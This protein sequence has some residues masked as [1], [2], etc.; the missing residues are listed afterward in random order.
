M[1][2]AQGFHT[3]FNSEAQTLQQA[4]LRHVAERDIAELHTASEEDEVDGVLC[5][6]KSTSE[7][8]VQALEMGMNQTTTQNPVPW[9]PHWPLA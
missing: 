7:K 1:R 8:T 4:F 3:R 2:T 6:E 9:T 5:A